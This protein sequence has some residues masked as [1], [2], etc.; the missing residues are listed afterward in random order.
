MN[1]RMILHSAQMVLRDLANYLHEED[2]DITTARRIAE[3]QGNIALPSQKIAYIA[4]QCGIAEG[5]IEA[6]YNA[7]RLIVDREAIDWLE[8]FYSTDRDVIVKTLRDGR[9]IL[10][11]ISIE[12]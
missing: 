2:I 11:S 3:C 5:L 6:V 10:D 8:D 1:Y 9:V 12:L 7:Q 4:G